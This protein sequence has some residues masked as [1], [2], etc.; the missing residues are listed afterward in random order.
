M[1]VCM[2]STV[3]PGFTRMAVWTDAR[4][5][6]LFC[7]VVYVYVHVYIVTLYSWHYFYLSLPL[8]CCVCLSSVL[9]SVLYSVWRV[10]RF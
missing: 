9:I 6:E 10:W 3:G 7:T 5:C 4:G 1:Y 8:P 2:Y